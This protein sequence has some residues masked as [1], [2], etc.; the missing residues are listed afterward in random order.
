MT[1]ER[2][3]DGLAQAYGRDQGGPAAGGEIGGVGE[4][5]V[6]DIEIDFSDLAAFGTEKRIGNLPVYSLPE[7]ALITEAYIDVDTA[8]TSSGAATLII[9]S[10]KTLIVLFFE[11]IYY[12]F[13]L[14]RIYYIQIEFKLE[15]K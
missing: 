2:N 7:G 3:D 10:I 6:A 4:D 15:K 1:I 8:F 12:P 5:R 14:Q 11:N 9:A 13:N